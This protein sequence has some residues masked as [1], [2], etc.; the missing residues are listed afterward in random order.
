MSGSEE[1]QDASRINRAAGCDRGGLASH[2]DPVAA[3]A[4]H[5]AD[6]DLRLVR[7]VWPLQCRKNREA[8]WHVFSRHHP[9]PLDVCG[10]NA[11]LRSEEEATKSSST[12]G[13]CSMRS[14]GPPMG[15]STIVTSPGPS[16]LPSLQ[17][18]A[19]GST[20]RPPPGVPGWQ[21][22]SQPLRAVPSLQ[23]AAPD[24]WA[25]TSDRWGA[26]GAIRWCYILGGGAKPSKPGGIP[27]AAGEHGEICF[28]ALYREC[29][30]VARCY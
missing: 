20:R 8:L 11:C 1:A 26:P 7:L 29:I 23:R 18:H 13:A 6:C 9:S 12:S 16:T 15:S 5:N 4:A 10:P 22:G 21:P 28:R 27:A 30:E 14:E 3:A 25:A 2:A 24:P 17:L 19:P